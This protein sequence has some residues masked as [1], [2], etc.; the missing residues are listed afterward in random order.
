MKKNSSGINA[1]RAYRVHSGCGVDEVEHARSG[2]YVEHLATAVKQEVVAWSP[3]QSADAQAGRYALRGMGTMR[4]GWTRLK[5]S[6]MRASDHFTGCGIRYAYGEPW[7]AVI[8]E[9]ETPS[10]SPSGHC[11][12]IEGV[13]MMDV[14]S[15]PD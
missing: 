13:E 5:R 1:R 10:Q 9:E 12:R 2:G 7:Q 6:R 11:G 4:K 14:A 3:V 8:G 15:L